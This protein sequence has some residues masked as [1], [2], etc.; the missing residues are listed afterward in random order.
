MNRVAF[1]QFG[2]A[3]ETESDSVSETPWVS[4]FLKQ[5][6]S[7]SIGFGV[8]N[9]EGDGQADLADHD[10]AQKAVCVYRS[11]HLSYWQLINSARSG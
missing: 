8:T 5:A 9:H 4:G 7:E 11:A 2:K 10:G 3:S 6:V 1:I